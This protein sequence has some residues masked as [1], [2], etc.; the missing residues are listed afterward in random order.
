M[1]P[2]GNWEFRNA[3]EENIKMDLR[4]TG[5]KLETTFD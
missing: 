5:M 3:W 4:E 2:Q 1:E